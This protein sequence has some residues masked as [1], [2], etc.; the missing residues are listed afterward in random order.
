MQFR[1]VETAF[2]RYRHLYRFIS[3]DEYPRIILAVPA[4]D[5]I[6]KPPSESPSGKFKTEGR[7]RLECKRDLRHII[8]S[9]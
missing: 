6:F 7:E 5:L 8:S 3:I 2:L 4:V 9:L 1:F